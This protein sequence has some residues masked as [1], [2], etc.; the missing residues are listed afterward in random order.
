[1]TR[2]FQ[3]TLVASV[4]ALTFCWQ[5]TLTADE[6]DPSIGLTQIKG[7][8]LSDWISQATADNGP[9]D[10]SQTVA[11]LSSA[12]LSENPKVKVVA[13]D[14]LAVLGPKAKGA[15]PALLAQFDHHFPW[16]RVSSPGGMS[17]VL[18]ACH[19]SPPLSLL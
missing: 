6:P 10:V 17:P 12:V 15:L 14:A 11:A 9:E 8:P 2:H 4:A 1:M 3:Y 5:L 7:K 19:V 18:N 13:A 16:V